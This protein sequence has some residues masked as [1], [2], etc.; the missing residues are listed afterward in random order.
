MA[1]TYT[2]HVLEE[3]QHTIVRFDGKV[4]LP[5]GPIAFRQNDA[6]GELTLIP[7]NAAQEPHPWI[8]F[9]EYVQSLPR[10]EYW[11]EFS[12]IMDER[13]MNQPPVDRKTFGSEKE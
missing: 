12:R 4:S 9:F 8:D 6:N 3:G 11:H 1:A 5:A 7:R 13:P 10:D 2:A